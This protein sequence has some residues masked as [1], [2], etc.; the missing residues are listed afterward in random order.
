MGALSADLTARGWAVWNLE[1]RPVGAGGGW[2]ATFRDVATGVDLLDL[3]AERH[4][5]DLGRVQDSADVNV[6]PEVSESYA[7]TARRAG[8][9]VDLVRVPGA[10][11]FTLLEP[12]SEAWAISAERLDELVLAR[13]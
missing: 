6:A 1:Y 11:H 3:L 7:S 9:D 12:T 5:L 2:P 13:P 4:A 10:D 8:D